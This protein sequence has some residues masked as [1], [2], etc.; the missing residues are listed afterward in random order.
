MDYCN[1][2]DHYTGQF[3]GHQ[4]HLPSL[5]ALQ[6]EV[7]STLSG[8]D[9]DHRGDFSTVTKVCLYK[10]SEVIADLNRAILSSLGIGSYSA[11]EALSRTSVENSIN[12]VLFADDF[13]TSRAKSVLLNYLNRSIDKAKKWRAYGKEKGDSQTM[14]RALELEEWLLDIKSRCADLEGGTKGWPDAFRR[15]EDAGYGH[16]YHVIFAPASDSAHGFSNDIFNDFLGVFSLME[17]RERASYFERHRA[18][19][20]SFAYYLA[21][22][23]ILFYCVAASHIAA[24]AEETEA[25]ER[26]LAISKELEEML[27]EHQSLFD[28]T[29]H[30]LAKAREALV[31]EE[32]SPV[33]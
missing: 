22:Y 30:S 28:I 10:V 11:V 33:P 26:F 3:L 23:A 4:R 15:F 2:P 19:K 20:I 17:E 12:L 6:R 29:Q 1:N 7:S 25:V 8:V 27:A 21:T 14:V 9:L 5:E 18:E 31:K 13:T 24:R 16:F 32:Q